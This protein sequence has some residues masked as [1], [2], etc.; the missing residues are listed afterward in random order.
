M[1]HNYLSDMQNENMDTDKMKALYHNV[2]KVFQNTSRDTRDPD[3][4]NPIKKNPLGLFP[5]FQ[6]Q[7]PP[8]RIQRQKHAHPPKI[9]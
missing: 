7:N 3:N 4:V 2:N 6:D 9:P 1:N 8:H 5:E